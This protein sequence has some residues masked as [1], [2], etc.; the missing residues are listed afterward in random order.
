MSKLTGEE[1]VIYNKGCREMNYSILKE[2]EN[3]AKCYARD[4][5]IFPNLCLIPFN[6]F[7]DFINQAEE[8]QGHQ[9]DRNPNRIVWHGLSVYGCE[10][11]GVSEIL[12]TYRHS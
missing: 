4:C 1:K 6:K 12:V 8:R 7:S 10:I 11:Q 9:F 3:K 2:I 5:N